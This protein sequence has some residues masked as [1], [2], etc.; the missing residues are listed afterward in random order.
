MPRAT[1]PATPAAAPVPVA[2]VPAQVRG[3][4]DVEVD[5]DRW[6]DLV[7]TSGLRGPGRELAAHAAFIGYRAG[8]LSLS[9][10]PEDDH[11]RAPGLV[12]LLGE[13]LAGALGGVPQVRFE[14]AKP[15]NGETLHE[16]SARQRDARQSAA[17][18]TFMGDPDV[19]KLISQH[20]ARVVPDSIRPIDD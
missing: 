16:R 12:K 19:Q 11:L 8:V 20:G 3:N 1:P 9:L 2:A 10:P 13:A 17:E 15:A 5:A 6:L 18:A 7:A 14:T 4:A